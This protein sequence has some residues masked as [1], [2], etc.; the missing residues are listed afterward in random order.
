M[1]IAVILTY[2][3]V[4]THEFLTNW[5][6]GRYVVSNYDIRNL[7][8]NSVKNVFSNIYIG[9]YAP[10]QM[11]SYMLDY[12]FFG[13][14]PQVYKLHNVVIHFLSGIFF[15]LILLRHFSFSWKAA[16]AAALI[17]LVHPVQVEGVVWISQRKT[18]LSG[19]FL[20]VSL[21]AFAEFRCHPDRG[22]W[23]YVAA[24]FSFILAL[25]SKSVAIVLIPLLI[26]FNGLSGT[27]KSTIKADVLRLL[28]FVIAGLA[29]ALVALYTQDPSI[30]GRGGISGYPGGS[31]WT[32]L[33]TM[34]PVL[35]RYLGM[36]FWPTRLSPA[37]HVEIRTT[38]D[39]VIVGA[40]VLIVVLTVV[41]VK[42]FQYSKPIFIWYTFAFVALLP[43][44]QIV[45]LVTLMNDRYL[46]LPM[47]GVSAFS[48]GLAGTSDIPGLPRKKL[49]TMLF[50]GLL[51]L[52]VWTSREQTAVWKNSLT[53]WQHA[54][55]AEP[56]SV[57]ARVGYAV[58]MIHAGRLESAESILREVL[59]ES[60]FQREAMVNLAG[61]LLRG[62]RSDEAEAMLLQ[63][64]L[65]YPNYSQGHE[66]LGI[67]RYET[68]QRAAAEI[69]FRRTI[70]LERN[71]VQARIA[72][73][74]ILLEK[75]ELIE[76]ENVLM[77]AWRFDD[78]RADLAY[79]LGCVKALQG[80]SLLAISYLERAVALGL[81]GLEKRLV[82]NDELDSLRTLEA[83]N[84]LLKSIHIK[85][86]EEKSKG[87]MG[88]SK[89]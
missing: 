8:L 49:G 88:K 52:M 19:F 58:A 29:C 63:A 54:V 85:T 23:W 51:I 59:S 47:L 74:T 68:R 67:L 86:G 33:L 43:V 32:T 71:S 27:G 12:K 15:F 44:S 1:A 14:N 39:W 24:V 66:L 69:S 26:L 38:P 4:I 16:V 61:L 40:L 34:L 10:M 21:L 60:P 57:V 30:G 41:A 76:A 62:Q 22:R 20:L 80:Q 45:P 42:L 72:L 73:G 13:L 87:V 78:S 25:L 31:W 3:G 84:E 36:I 6:D 53:L 83:F 18:V 35:G 81:P 46:Y 65:L 89:N 55:E 70:E 28:P 2:S 50:C 82:G 17:F 9:N 77:E 79:A 48:A 56:E 7:D 37:Y 5:D 11:L 64:T 75:R